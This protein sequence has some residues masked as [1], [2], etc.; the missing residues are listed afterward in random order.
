M[1]EFF[2]EAREDI[3]SIYFSDD[4]FKDFMREAKKY[5]L[6]SKDETLELFKAYK[7]G[8][9]EAYNKLVNCNLRLVVSVAHS[10][11]NA[12]SH[13]TIMDLVQ[14]GT[15]GLMTA[16]RKYD[17]SQ[18]SLSNYAIIW[19]RQAISRSIMNVDSEIKKTQTF[20]SAKKKYESYLEE[21]F[22]ANKDI[23]DDE[24]ICD[25]LDISMQTLATIKN[26]INLSP[27]SLNALVQSGEDT[28]IGDLTGTV[29]SNYD[30]VIESFD[31]TRLLIVLKEILKPVSYYVIYYRYLCSS[32]KRLEDVAIILNIS[33]ERVR[34]IEAQ[35]LRKCK[36]YMGDNNPKFLKVINKFNEKDLKR[37]RITPV[38][39]IDIIKFLY[40]KSSLED[41]EIRVLHYI[42]ISKIIYSK[43]ELCQKLFCSLEELNEVLLSLRIKMNNISN[44]LKDFEFFKEQTMK[45]YGTKIFDVNFLGNSI[46]YNKIQSLFSKSS[47]EIMDMYY[48]EMPYITSAER[49]LLVRFFR[50]PKSVV[51]SKYLIE[52]DVYMTIFG[53]KHKQAPVSKQKLYQKFMENL[54]KFDEEQILYLECFFFF[55]K[56]KSEFDQ[57]YPNSICHLHRNMVH[58]KLLMICYNIYGILQNDFN[59]ERYLRVKRD[60]PRKLSERRVFLLDMFY[61]VNGKALSIK[62]ISE[63]L[64][65]DYLRIHGEIRGAR[66]FAIKLDTVNNYS[67]NI[68]FATYK[69]FVLDRKYIFTEETRMI[70]KLFV[71]DELSYDEISEKTGLT[72]YRISNIITDGIRKIDYYR[73]GILKAI[74]FSPRE[75]EKF[76]LEAAFEMSDEDKK[77]LYDK[78]VDLLSNEE[79]MEKYQISIVKINHVMRK[80]DDYYLKWKTKEVEISA[81]DFAR[82]IR[83]HPSDSVLDQEE[84]EI[85]SLL[86]G[87]RCG[88]NINGARYSK[89]QIANLLGRQYSTIVKRINSAF[90]KLKARKVDIMKPELGFI[91]RSELNHILSDPHLPLSDDKKDIL[92]YLFELN[93]YPYKSLEDLA[94]MLKINIPSL[95]RSFERAIIAIF[96]YLNKEIPGKLDYELDILPKLRYFSKSDELLIRESFG[97]KLTNSEISEKYNLVLEF[98]HSNL[99]RIK[100]LLHEMSINPD[101]RKFD[102]AYY[103]GVVDNPELP[104]Y[105][106]IELAKTIFNLHHGE[107]ILGNMSIPKIMKYLNI[108]FGESTINKLL[109]SLMVSVYNYKAGERKDNLLTYDSVSSYYERNWEYM[110][111]VKKEK[112]ETYLRNSGKNRMIFL[113][114]LINTSII[115]DLLKEQNPDFFD[116]DSIKREQ[117]IEILRKYH[118]ELDLETCNC[119]MC[120]FDIREREIMSG[121]DINHVFKILSRLEQYKLALNNGETLKRQEGN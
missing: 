22:K 55:K 95:K 14:E 105:G 45:H 15:T 106:D 73:F 33:R 46:D 82:E 27:V 104:F 41:L 38:E 26:S 115:Y 62:E 74:N 34:Q 60:F 40:L 68:D 36:P 20:Y 64:Q 79:I 2:G 108:P 30:E 18:G 10:F 81:D 109:F 110:S 31:N 53:Y 5:P 9:Q 114:P 90:L 65:E 86:Y 67:L 59:K 1:D 84:K 4:V 7:N 57:K 119:L 97:N 89:L 94:A 42:L 32:Q 120:T 54:D 83:N 76:I 87:I 103:R 24:E 96:K 91:S 48:S 66:D 23:P 102:F 92:C 69:P 70:L 58:L 21:C 39:P 80:F 107:T 98:V 88:Y 11:V 63:L 8:D 113:T 35:A 12:A 72:K 99:Q 52:K 100:V 77:I 13:M 43:K 6:L 118:K 78:I 47:E 16:I 85:V 121:K 112:Y 75:F 49:K 29:D 28:E 3:K 111:E 17:P 101:C 19:I 116:F 93:N 25:I 51:R 71:Y 61:G 117:V 50:V 56:E 37:Y 44:N